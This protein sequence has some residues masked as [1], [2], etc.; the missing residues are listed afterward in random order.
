[1]CRAVKLEEL[2]AMDDT[3]AIRELLRCCGST[4]WAS[5]MAR[6]RPFADDAALAR[7][8]DAMWESLDPQDW[9]EAFAAHPRIGAGRAGISAWSREEQSGVSGAMGDRLAALN[10]AYEERFGYIFIVCAA[11]RTG[12]EILRTLERRMQNDPGEELLE[13]AGE[14]R[15]ITALR[16]AKLTA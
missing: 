13:A 11:G 10:L 9:R 5:L 14:Q 2:N 8:A 3:S 7:T 1:M 16:L 4:R 15:K 12:H 6:A